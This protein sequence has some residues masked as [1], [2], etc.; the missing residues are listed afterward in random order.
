MK[1][2]IMVLLLL[3]MGFFGIGSALM[4]KGEYIHD[5]NEKEDGDEQEM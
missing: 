2:V 5:R 3:F 4:K 1:E